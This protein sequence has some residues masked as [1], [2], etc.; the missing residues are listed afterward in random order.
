MVK[1]FNFFKKLFSKK[2]TPSHYA[3][4]EFNHSALGEKMQKLS[5]DL[6]RCRQDDALKVLINAVETARNIQIIELNRLKGDKIEQFHHQLGRLEALNDLI[7]FVTSS[8]DVEVYNQRKEP[9][10][11]TVKI[12]RSDY[13]RSQPVI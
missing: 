10:K 11:K 9:V 12:L 3:L 1:L 8:L 7:A 13:E 6:F 4:L 5:V 2:K